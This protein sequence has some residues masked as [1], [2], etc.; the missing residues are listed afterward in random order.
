MR[1]STTMLWRSSRGMFEVWV[2][3]EG[4]GKPQE[5]FRTGVLLTLHLAFASP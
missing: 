5:I 2:W 3:N 1:M 4:V